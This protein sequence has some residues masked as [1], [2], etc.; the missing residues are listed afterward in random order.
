MPR[1]TNQRLALPATA[2]YARFVVALAVIAVI[3]VVG[4]FPGTAYAHN[5]LT[6]SSPADGA[7]LDSA[8]SQI[9]WVFD[10]AVP[11]DTLTVTLT[12]ATGVRTDLDGS[13]HGPAGDNEVVTPLPALQSGLVSLRWRLVGPDGHV[14]TGRVE[15]TIADTAPATTIA[16]AGPTT[17]PL[18]VDGTP[19]GGEVAKDT[20]FSTPSA[21][22]WVLRYASYLAI[23]AVA[24]I[25]L[26]TAFVWSGAGSHPLLRR[27]VG[28]ALLAVGVLGFLQLLVVASDVSGKAPWSSFGSIDAATSTDAGL[29][30]AIRVVLAAA[31]ALV[32][33]RQAIKHREVYWTAVSLSVF[34]LLGTWAYAGHSRSMRWSDLGVVT[35]V[36]HHA[37][38]AAWI[39]GLAI[40]GWV[41]IPRAAPDVMVP[42]VR[43]F[44]RVAAISVALLV[45]TGAIQS[46]R[47]VGS[48]FD[49]F[50]ARHGRYLAVKL[51]LLAVMLGV[52]SVNRGRINQRLDDPVQRAGHT[53]ALRRAVLAEFAIGLA[54]I[55]VTAAMVVSPPSSSDDATAPPDA[56][57]HIYYTT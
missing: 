5:N 23:L 9:T 16:S 27:L 4:L 40:V 8:P 32:L 22:R 45:G 28:R 57:R 11:L 24:G 30:F 36:V 3:A 14:V 54:V 20:E 10:K 35:D 7:E 15:F 12:D 53:G 17:V 34:G 26:T 13:T 44:S 38:A 39:A 42:A 25:L 47:L 41:L 49:L 33:F 18:P 2:L 31:L 1:T 19:P 21:V 50:D 51:V 55:A 37:A 43:R 52:A 46:L 29:A 48:P 6:S 56:D